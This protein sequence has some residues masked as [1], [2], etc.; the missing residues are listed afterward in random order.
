MTI[1]AAGNFDKH[2]AT[3]TPIGPSKTPSKKPI[4]PVLALTDRM[5][6]SP[7]N[8]ANRMIQN[9]DIPSLYVTTDALT[10]KS[11]FPLGDWRVP[12]SWIACAR[13]RLRAH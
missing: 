12:I 2:T 4:G 5:R 13:Q 6:N 9:Q 1:S 8:T 7:H 10:R 11:P 3:M